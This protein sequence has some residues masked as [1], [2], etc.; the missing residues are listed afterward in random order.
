M[1]PYP[2]IKKHLDKYQ[3]VITSDNK[4]Y[5]LH[6]ARDERFF[7]GEKIVALRKCIEPTF[8][9]SDFDCYVSAAFYVIK[10]NRFNMKYLTGLLNSK[11][12]AFWL[13]H[14]GKMQGNNYQIDAEPLLNIPLPSLIP[15]NQ[16]IADQ[17]IQK[18]DQILTLTQS[19]D[20]DTNQE[21]QKKIKKI[22][23]EIDMLVYEL[24]GLD[25]EEI[26]II[27]SSL[28]SK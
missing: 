18:V 1:E 26:E 13:K 28:N 24:Y 9:Y 5:G 3:A 14:K 20:Y 2:N 23:K 7:K 16:S 10:T 17:I 11:L 4:P 12:V 21:K 27:E 19:E 15:S 22:E 8:T 6:R 25:N